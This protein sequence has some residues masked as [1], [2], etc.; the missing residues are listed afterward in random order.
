MKEVLKTMLEHP[1]ATWFVVGV[2]ASGVATVITSLKKT[3]TI[4]V[5]SE[6]KK[7]S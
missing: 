7:E 4:N 6:P 5:I 2:T 3:V 1:I